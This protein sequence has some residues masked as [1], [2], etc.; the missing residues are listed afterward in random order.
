MSFKIKDKTVFITVRSIIVLLL[1]VTLCILVLWD[2]D[3]KYIKLFETTLLIA[4]GY[5]FGRG[6]IDKQD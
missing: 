4:V 1:V 6:E 5:L 2:S 3:D